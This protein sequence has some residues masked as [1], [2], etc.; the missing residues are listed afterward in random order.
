L[1]SASPRRH[2][3]DALRVIAIAL[4][5]L[6][7]SSISFQ[8]WAPLIGFI[9]NA[10][11]LPALW[12][13]MSML[14]VW[15]IPL[16]FFISGMGVFFSMKNRD[17]KSLLLERTRRI[18]IPLLFGS[19]AIVPLHVLILQNHYDIPLSYQPSQAHLWFLTNIFCYVLLLLPLLRLLTKYPDSRPAQYLRLAVS[20]PWLL[21]ILTL[22]GLLEILIVTPVR[23]ETYAMNSHGFALGFLAF[24]FGFSFAY[25]GSGFTDTARKWKWAHLLIASG[26]FSLR[27]SELSAPWT[28]Y[29]TALESNAWILTIFAFAHI[30]L[31]RNSRVLNYLTPAAYPVYILHMAYQYLFSSLLFPTPLN[32]WLKFVLLFLTTLSASILSYELIIRRIKPLRPLF[33][34]NIL[35]K[36]DNQK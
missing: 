8:L 13:A 25:S 28:L 9:S 15:R 10:E 22:F 32:P 31:N 2:D 27:I 19:V 36:N 23:F 7:H 24:F 1:T 20:G 6:Y 30:H 33:G 18:L 17:S 34:L 14:N 35:P 16:L 5:I 12:P 4:L 11:P 26:L 21:P 29:L 3:I